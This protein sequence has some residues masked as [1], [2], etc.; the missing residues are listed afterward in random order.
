VQDAISFLT[1]NN[2]EVARLRSF[3][4]IEHVYLDFGIA[5]RDVLL[6]CDYLPPELVQLAG[7]LGLG[8]E[9]SQ[10]PAYSTDEGPANDDD[11][12]RDDETREVPS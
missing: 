1:V 11:R 3:P 9:L 8:I 12:I 4:G 7:A 5:R 10:Y 2:H 6:Q